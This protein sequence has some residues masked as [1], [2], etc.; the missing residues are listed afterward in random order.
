MKKIFYFLAF[1]FSFL[2]FMPNS[3]DAAYNGALGYDYSAVSTRFYFYVEH[4]DADKNNIYINV[5]GIPEKIKMLGDDSG[6]YVID[7]EGDLK[8]KSYYYTICYKDSQCVDVIDP[9]TP[10]LNVEQN[11]NVVLDN[12]SMWVEGFSELVTLNTT[13]KEKIYAI[14]PY[15]FVKTL[16]VSN[17]ENNETIDSVFEKMI[18]S[19]NY[20]N[21]SVGFDY[22]VGLGMNYLEMEDIYD[23]SNYYIPNLS[24]S[25]KLDNY[26]SIIE[27]KNLVKQYKSSKMNV[28][29]KTD[30]LNPNEK[31]RSTLS[32]LSQDYIVDNKININNDLM[33]RFITEVYK[34]W[35]SEYKIDGF[36]I[37]NA[38]LYNQ[39]YLNNL[40]S[41]LKKINNNL[42]IYTDSNKYSNFT[43]N[44]LQTLLIGSLENS[45]NEGIINNK[46]YSKDNLINILDAITSGHYKNYDNYI[47]SSKKVINNFGSLDGLDIYSKLVLISGLGEKESVTSSKL[48]LALQ[49]IF[50]SE[51]IPR[52]IGGNEFLNVNIIPTSQIEST[53]S[54][55]KVCNQSA[56]MCY[57]KGNDKV[58]EWN[59]LLKN[60][61]DL[62]S[63]V[64]YRNMFS[65]YHFSKYILKR[66]S[67]VLIKE[68]YLPQG[69]LY[70]TYSF[71]SRS[72]GDLMSWN[73]IINFS[74][75]N[76]NLPSI[77]NKAKTD[78]KQ[79]LFIGNATLSEEESNLSGYSFL[80]FAYYKNTKLPNW[81]Y[82][83][84]LVV[85]CFI[86]FGTRYLLSK[87]LKETKGIDYSAIKKEKRKKEKPAKEKGIIETFYGKD[88]FGVFKRD[89]K[90]KE[91]NKTT[92][93]I[94][95]EGISNEKEEKEIKT[96]GNSKQRE[97][98]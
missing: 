57:L 47:N 24:Y 3:V 40:I 16:D 19:V 68:E 93:E 7:I 9:F 94:K 37:E 10:S 33:K 28:I 42:F 2:I 21:I 81:V 5:E 60:G 63:I 58:V 54:E 56:T 71:N 79:L 27:F 78:I 55:F 41:E 25:S 8:N 34:H 59:Y 46:D 15:N 38:D 31:L 77:K 61:S 96:E 92:E 32:Y 14:N 53:P 66:A 91:K 70:V 75:D 30:F 86:I 89:K 85:L 72:N 84:L 67:S 90:K 76:V 45:N 80:T 4:D 13:N 43:D 48:K 64:T 6:I 39:D 22:L 1:I 50:A 44:T 20:S 35:V 36:Y 65:E 11:K 12:N 62:K 98:K 51:G 29:L 87:I 52:I 18:T 74:T 26:S 69:I 88:I 83:I 49:I 95:D 73:S 97:D 82:F 17:V 23:S